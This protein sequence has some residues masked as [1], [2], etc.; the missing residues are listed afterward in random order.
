M[1]SA[2]LQASSNIR[3]N[4]YNEKREARVL[5]SCWQLR[6]SWSLSRD[7]LQLWALGRR[8]FYDVLHLS[9]YHPHTKW[10]LN[11]QMSQSPAQ[12]GYNSSAAS[13]M[14]TA[15]VL[16]QKPSPISSFS[17]HLR[18]PAMRH[19]LCGWLHPRLSLL[20]KIA[21]PIGGCSFVFYPIMHALLKLSP[22]L[23]T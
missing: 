16:C 14:K 21:F 6:K 19:V 3:R 8:I 1:I 7:H 15:F 23:L 22:T 20:W 11:E 13:S 17:E 2:A 4:C 12:S 5:T 10:T 9:C 18:S